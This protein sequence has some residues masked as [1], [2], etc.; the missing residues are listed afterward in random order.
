MFWRRSRFGV[1]W[2]AVAA[3]VAAC[4][5]KS[6]S[7]NGSGGR[8]S[9]SGGGGG[10]PTTQPPV[11]CEQAATLYAQLVDDAK[12]CDPHQP[13]PCTF[14][15]SDALG[16]GCETFVNP[17]RWD[18]SL[19]MA[20]GTHYSALACGANG[21]CGPCP[22]PLRGTCSV[23]DG[24]QDSYVPAPGRGCKV[25]GVI[26]SDGSSR[27]VDPTSCNTCTCSDGTLACTDIDCPKPCPAGTQF[28]T[29]CAQCGAA[30]ACE[31]VEHACHPTCTDACDEGT[32]IDGACI[33]DCVER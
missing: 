10:G 27:I 12:S 4:G 6:A 28:A 8:A 30:D 31:V 24:C 32:C 23:M 33:A 2:C 19:A 25:D 18:D 5:G 9:D 15:V 22:T 7:E 26:Y 21:N 16:C 20:F 13:N 29:S 3:L 17:A 1:A 11:S 14:R